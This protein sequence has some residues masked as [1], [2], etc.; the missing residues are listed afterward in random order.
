M[1]RKRTATHGATV[2]KCVLELSFPF[3]PNSEFVLGHVYFM[4]DLSQ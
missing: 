1:L 4:K 2:M 3:V